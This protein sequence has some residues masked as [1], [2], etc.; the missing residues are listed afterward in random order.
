[1]KQGLFLAFAMMLSVLPAGAED[2]RLTLGGDAYAAGQS[3]VLDAPVPHD[4]FVAGFDT[5]LGQRVAGDAHIA[6]F[7][8]KADQ[9]V[10]GD[11]YA[12]GFSV[13]I[14]Q[15]V[16]G[17]A[18]AFGNSVVV[19]GSSSIAGNA[20]LSGAR[21]TL[22]VPVSGTALVSAETLTLNAPISGDFEFFGNRIEFGPNA[23][24]GGLVRVHAPNPIDL[25]PQV[26]DADRVS[27]QKLESTDYAGQAGSTAGRVLTGIWPVV[28]A[29][30]LWWLS[31][32]VLGALI[33]ALMPRATARF[34]R[35][36]A[37]QPLRTL[38]LGI[39]GFA[40][41]AGLI[42]VAALTIVGIVL[43]PVIAILA[44][45]LCVCAYL[46]GVYLV[47]LRA[48]R[49]F[50]P[51]DT[52]IKRVAALVVGILLAGLI[53]MLPFLGWLIS[54]TL[55]AYGFGIFVRSLIDRLWGDPRLPITPAPLPEAA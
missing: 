25:P 13:N 23:R 52:A 49:A 18:T 37:T 5:Q 24:I 38:G 34:E 8:V 36:A 45:V 33:I 11:L 50:L 41:T 10:G 35:R 30:G 21:V 7:D 9:P 47:A 19:D 44:L 51:I 1:M 15:P 55:M 27:Y 32:V 54:L 6:G 43:I 22:S 20:R 39:I 16:G 46:V 3:G 48:G 31:L 40:A 26:A 12:A 29:A 53:G 14:S 4:A 28:W 2:S 42:P 17:D